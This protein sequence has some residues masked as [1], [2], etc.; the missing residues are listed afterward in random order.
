MS[1][2]GANLQP[3]AARGRRATRRRGCKKEGSLGETIMII[4]RGMGFAGGG[5]GTG[6][7]NEKRAEKASGARRWET[8]AALRVGISNLSS[9]T[10]AEIGRDPGAAG[11]RLKPIAS[12]PYT[13]MSS[14]EDAPI[15]SG[16]PLRANSN[17]KR[18]LQ[19]QRAC[20]RCRQKKS[21]S[22]FSLSFLL[23]VLTHPFILA[24]L[25]CSPLY[26]SSAPF[27]YRAVFPDK[28]QAM[29]I[30]QA[31]DALIVRR[32]AVNASSQNRPRCASILVQWPSI[33]RFVTPDTRSSET[34][35][36]LAT[37]PHVILDPSYPPSCKSYVDT[38]ETRLEKM[39]GMLSRVCP[40]HLRP[41]ASYGYRSSCIRTATSRK[42]WSLK[43]GP[44]AF[45]PRLLRI[46]WLPTMSPVLPMMP[47]LCLHPLA[48]PIHL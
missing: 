11:D 43:D 45:N 33:N 23:L 19:N 6:Q 31:R 10:A 5:G 22:C 38:L 13:A 44:V 46:S 42:K 25:L 21:P 12:Q 3:C 7:E 39:E 16:V 20:D 1:K 24:S 29:E 2:G 35:N 40:Y 27:S 26:D 41:A 28:L 14:D 37:P 32:L 15:P 17:K 34:V 4:D 36:S 8:G 48:P 47:L 9:G 18:R 30:L